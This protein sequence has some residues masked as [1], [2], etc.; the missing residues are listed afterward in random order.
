MPVRRLQQPRGWAWTIAVAILKPVLLATTRQDWHHGERIPATGGVVLA[1]NHTSHVDPLT[2]AHLVYDHGRLAR[3]L[4]KSGL[5]RNRFLG[6]F[7]RAAG[8]IP[9]ER[10]S[11]G[12]AAYAAA[13]DAV[14]AGECV[15]VYPEGTIT[16]D[17]QLWPMTGK[18][19]A[20]RI[21][22][23][24]G[25]PVLPVGQ[26]GAHELLAPYSKRPHLFPPTTIHLS[27][28]E[29]VDLSDLAAGPVTTEVVHA[30]TERIQ[31]AIVAEVEV[32]RGE[33]APAERFDLRRARAAE[34]AAREAQESER[35]ED[36]DQKQDTGDG[37][38][39]P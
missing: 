13:V 8:Q 38:D 21:A 15:V 25:C 5:F 11:H 35:L 3:F 22:L 36:R 10:E 2:A 23:E 16:R 7:L 9:V 39:T 26:W 30:A 4:A 37:G 32:L 12:H 31:A 33:K 29:P 28:G 6:F 34:R 18:T 19:G 14:R 1:V 27:V 17:P 20:A 24:T